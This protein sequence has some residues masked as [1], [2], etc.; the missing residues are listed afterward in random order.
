MPLAGRGATVG[1]RPAARRSVSAR[2]SE[3]GLTL[4]RGCIAIGGTV[5]GSDSLDAVAAARAA[6]LCANSP[7]RRSTAAG[8]G[9][10]GSPGATADGDAG[11]GRVA[12]TST[13]SGVTCR[14]GGRSASA[15][16][17]LPAASRPATF[18]GRARAG[19]IDAFCDAPTISGVSGCGDV[20]HALAEWPLLDATG[21]NNGGASRHGPKS[22]G[23]RPTASRPRRSGSAATNSSAGLGSF[24]VAIDG[25]WGSGG[26]AAIDS[27]IE[28]RMA[29]SS[30]SINSGCRS[31]RSPAACQRSNTR[32]HAARR[33]VKTARCPRNVR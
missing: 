2:A 24:G 21:G 16:E 30:Q 15:G 20:R 12:R 17:W 9:W 10:D 7:G 13:M 4:D 26:K 11:A 31:K 27:G 1:R 29:A 32:L 23:V 18:R 19:P 14:F 5:A 22:T 33:L 6:G 8:A 3:A 25:K 28:L